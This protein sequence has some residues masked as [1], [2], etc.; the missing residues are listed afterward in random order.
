MLAI[1]GRH[2]GEPWNACF[3]RVVTLTESDFRAG[4]GELKYLNSYH[5]L[6]RH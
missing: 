4:L 3:L 6:K 2:N 1:Y 5:R